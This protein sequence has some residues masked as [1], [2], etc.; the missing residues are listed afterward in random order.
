MKSTARKTKL[1]KKTDMGYEFSAKIDFK[2]DFS[3]QIEKLM[4]EKRANDKLETEIKKL[5]EEII[6]LL[7]HKKKKDLSY[8]FMIG[9]KLL[10]LDNKNFR[11]ISPYSIYRRITE[12]I[13]Q[14]LPHIKDSEI[15]QKH[16]ETMYRLAHVDE[17][18]I[19]NANWDQWYEIMKFKEIYKNEEKMKKIL[20]LIKGKKISGPKL[21]EI[22]HSNK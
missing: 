12:E 11:E 21:R 17:N 3:T 10:F 22:I 20:K 6:L 14:I 5:S 7:K 8:Y 19:H 15:A 18:Y 1:G 13:P 16:L 2:E 4:K 9:K